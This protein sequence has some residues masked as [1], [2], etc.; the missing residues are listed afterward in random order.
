MYDRDHEEKKGA[1]DRDM[2]KY[3]KI[4][5]H[6]ALAKDE[7]NSKVVVESEICAICQSEYKDEENIGTLQFGHE[8]HMNCI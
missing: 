1:D 6:H 2:L 7:V 8:Y 5:T 3:L 4:R